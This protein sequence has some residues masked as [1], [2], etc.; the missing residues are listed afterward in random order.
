M[1]ICGPNARAG[2]TESA[3]A[4][5]SGPRVDVLRPHDRAVAARSMACAMARA[6]GDTGTNSVA[7]AY[8][9]LYGR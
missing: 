8:A 5:M 4:I 7:K 9:A 6:T 2:R 1:L 3:S